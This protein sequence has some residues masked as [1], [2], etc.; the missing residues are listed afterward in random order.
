MSIPKTQTKIETSGTRSASGQR[1]HGGDGSPKR[2]R[3]TR[4]R[5]ID[6]PITEETLGEMGKALAKRLNALVDALDQLEPKP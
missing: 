4:S 5:T 6:P 3:P 1:A 2:R